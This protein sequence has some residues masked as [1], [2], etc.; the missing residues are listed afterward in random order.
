MI[1][2]R[3]LWSCEQERFGDFF[4]RGH[5]RVCLWFK[6]AADRRRSK[7]SSVRSF[8]PTDRRIR[9][10][11]KNEVLVCILSLLKMVQRRSSVIMLPPVVMVAP[12]KQ[13]GMSSFSC[14]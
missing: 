1:T 9:P 8:R 5:Y 6:P 13:S 4:L 12:S 10:T 11:D 2:G 14:L 7:C 3:K